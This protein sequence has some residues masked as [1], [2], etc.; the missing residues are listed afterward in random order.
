VNCDIR[1]IVN[2]GCLYKCPFRYAHFNLFS[3]ITAA[4]GAGTGAQLLNTFGD[5]YFDKCI[6]IRVRD[7][8]QL[9]RSP[10]IR[11]EDI[12][13]YERIGIEDFKIAGRANA[14]G[15][16]T[17]CMDAYSRRSYEGNLLELL[18]CPSELRYMFYIDNKKLEGCINQWKSCNK[19][20]DTCRYCDEVTS[21]VLSVKK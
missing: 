12:V 20:C 8:S 3:H 13:E 10:W 1:V 14:V 16:I 4:S 15:W 21:R 18:D 11:P 19:M 6:S 7:P 5:Y 9:I 2:E 17:A